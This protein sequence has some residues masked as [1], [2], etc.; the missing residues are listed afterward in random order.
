MKIALNKAFDEVKRKLGLPESVEFRVISSI[1]GWSISRR[2]EVRPNSFRKYL[3]GFDPSTRVAT[4]LRELEA[5]LGAQVGARI[6]LYFAG[7]RIDGRRSVAS[8][9]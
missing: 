5:R 2:K 6:E 3:E 1:G 4:F 7:R 9:M 8:L